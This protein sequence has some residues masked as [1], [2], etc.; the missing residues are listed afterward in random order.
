MS[1]LFILGIYYK[2]LSKI[3]QERFFK[4][5]FLKKDNQIMH[6]ELCYSQS[7]ICVTFCSALYLVRQTK[8]GCEISRKHTHTHT[9]E[10]EYKK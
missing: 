4:V 3:Y 2:I 1:K 9:I 5:T 7:A 6:I 10:W 8:A